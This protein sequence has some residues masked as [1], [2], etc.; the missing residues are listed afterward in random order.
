MLPNLLQCD[1]DHTNVD[2]ILVGLQYDK[3][4]Q[5]Q[6]KSQPRPV[7]I[8]YT[9]CNDICICFDVLLQSLNFNSY[10]LEEQKSR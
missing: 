3:S 6:G 1:H 9:F 7:S 10:I 4:A 8:S 5:I 2:V